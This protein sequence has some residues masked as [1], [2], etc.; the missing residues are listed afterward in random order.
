[1]S[2]RLAPSCVVVVMAIPLLFSVAGAGGCIWSVIFLIISKTA[3]G[4]YAV[5]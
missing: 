1:M 5:S 2:S 3:A 4:V